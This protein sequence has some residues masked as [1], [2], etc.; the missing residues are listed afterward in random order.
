MPS[1]IRLVGADSP[2][3]VTITTPPPS[4]AWPAAAGRS[5]DVLSAA[6]VT[7]SYQLNATVVPTNSAAHWTDS[8]PATQRFYRVR[9]SN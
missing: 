2:F 9:T 3:T 8:I 1:W 4:M 7:G 5:Y 6:N